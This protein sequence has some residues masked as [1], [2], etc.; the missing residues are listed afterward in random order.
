MT[1]HR[2]EHRQPRRKNGEEGSQEGRGEEGRSEGHEEG[3]EEAVVGFAA[4]ALQRHA[5]AGAAL[6]ALVSWT[7]GGCQSGSA[8]A[9]HSPAATNGCTHS[10]LTGRERER[11][12]C[13]RT[14][15]RRAAGQVHR[16]ER[17]Y[18]P[19]PRRQQRKPPQ[20]KRLR[21]RP[22]NGS[23][24]TQS[25][26]AGARHHRAPFRFCAKCIKAEMLECRRRGFD[27]AAFGI[28]A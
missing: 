27:I 24:V 19:W 9:G 7:R 21:K 16:L 25:H 23:G 22:R 20:R 11:Q 14:Q 12:R 13:E 10:P 6:V 4:T 2:K 1:V 8:A 5:A 18:T 17:G 3:R 15:L 28:P 26:T